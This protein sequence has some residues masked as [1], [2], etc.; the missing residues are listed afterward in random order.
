ML[1]FVSPTYTYKIGTQEMSSTL[2]NGVSTATYCSINTFISL[3]AS[4][5]LLR[6]FFPF[7]G[8]PSKDNIRIYETHHMN[9]I[10]IYVKCT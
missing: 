6:C 2:S 7:P 9:Y 1:L 8:T 3:S 10:Y 5:P 4:T